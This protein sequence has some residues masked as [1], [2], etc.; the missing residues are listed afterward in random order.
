[1]RKYNANETERKGP[2]RNSPDGSGR[3]DFARDRDRILY[4]SAFRSLA[5]KTQVVSAQELGRF[6]TRLTHSL[7]VAQ[8]G[9]DLAT[10]LARGRGTP[11]VDLVEAACLAHDIGHPPFGH[12]GEKELCEVMDKYF[13][14]DGFEGNAQTFRIVT[15][16]ST[17]SEDREV[18]NPIY[19]LNLTRATLRAIAKYPWHR[20]ENP[21]LKNAGK[22]SAYS[23]EDEWLNWILESRPADTLLP[24]EERIMDWCDDV[25]Y[26][27][28]DLE[29]FYTS[30]LIPIDKLFSRGIES[31]AERENF[32]DWL[33]NLDWTEKNLRFEGYE[34][35][36]ANKSLLGLTEKI[37]VDSPYD[38]T[39]KT[40][41]KLHC[42][43]SNLISHFVDSVVLKGR[44]ERSYYSRLN[45]P[46][47]TQ[48]E[49]QLLK[50]L[51]PY[52]VIAKRKLAAQQQGQR[53]IVRD[54][55]TWHADEPNLLPEDRLEELY[56]H[57]DKLRAAC[58]HIASLTEIHAYKLHRRLSGQNVGLIT[59]LI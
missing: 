22:W 21:D 33:D 34:R 41:A 6:H 3:T 31:D 29:D 7:K 16:L 18:K 25:T 46:D 17:R 43:I 13:K 14:T 37:V 54:L 9:R 36:R 35:E 23:T 56:C 8:L 11:D 53:R 28:H 4:S 12:A 38:A 39:R 59:D 45:I 5:G 1:V 19:G 40:K 2:E 44:P 58:D 24:V 20:G 52:Y 42:S 15:Y 51:V 10:R 47:D 55:L 32:L 48:F 57:N 49:C 30:G 26:A 50:T 27:C